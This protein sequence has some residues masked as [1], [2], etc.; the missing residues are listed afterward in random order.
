[1]SGGLCACP[2]CT[3]H[4]TI[5]PQVTMRLAIGAADIDAPLVDLL[6]WLNRRKAVTLGSCYDLADAVETALPQWR[7][8]HVG[9]PSL[10]HIV[11]RRWGFVTGMD[12][13]AMR[14]LAEAAISAG[15]R[16][17]S[18]G[19]WLRVAFPPEAVPVLC[20]RLAVQS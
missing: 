8:S 13:A 19:L 16:V 14:Q 9:S 12:G 17:W 6:W 10:R 15:G 11:E 18:E 2:V 5:H 3:S 20:G 1:M 4:G 7:S